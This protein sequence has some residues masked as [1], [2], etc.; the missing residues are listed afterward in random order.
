[1]HAVK[2]LTTHSTRLNLVLLPKALT[3]TVSIQQL[4]PH[5]ISVCLDIA[6]SRQWTQPQS[7]DSTATNTLFK[8]KLRTLTTNSKHTVLP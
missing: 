3:C 1:M 6:N 4:A 5:E 7:V 8:S 2:H